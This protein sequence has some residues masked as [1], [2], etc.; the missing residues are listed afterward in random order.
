MYRRPLGVVGCWEKKEEFEFVFCLG[1]LEFCLFV[2]F[3][4]LPG[5][6]TG[7]RHVSTLPTDWV[8]KLALFLFWLVSYA[9]FS[10]D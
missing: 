6:E 3:N 10:Y 1:P 5:E 7:L 8:Y 4:G 2:I 9:T